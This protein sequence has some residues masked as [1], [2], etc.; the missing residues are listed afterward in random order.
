MAE[1]E[2]CGRNISELRK[3]EIDGTVFNVCNQCSELGEEIIDRHP[4]T[5]KETPSMPNISEL[6]ENFNE[7]I[8]KKRESLGLKQKELAL[9]M[10][11]SESLLKRIEHGFK[12]TDDIAKRIERFLKIKVFQSD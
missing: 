9:S 3:V 8:R 5:R 1:C 11:I 12:P 10:G 7:I 6:K 2:I 4:S